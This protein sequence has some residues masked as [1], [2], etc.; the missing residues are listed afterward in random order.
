MAQGY[1]TGGR[2]SGVKNKATIEREIIAAAQA[3][4][5]G[6]QREL[7]IDALERFRIHCEGVASHFMPTVNVPDDQQGRHKNWDKTGEWLDRAIFCA[8][9][10]AKYQSPQLRAM[11]V[12]TAPPPEMPKEEVRRFGLTVYEGG[13]KVEPMKKIA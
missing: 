2:K 7:A 9:E 5:R 1:K 4:K 8:R 12:Q 6:P 10:L 3:A 13:R 11:M